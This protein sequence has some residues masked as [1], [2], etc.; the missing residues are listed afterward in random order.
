MH[1]LAARQCEDISPAAADNLYEL[2]TLWETLVTLQDTRDSS[3]PGGH[4]YSA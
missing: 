4:G 1:A 3:A 2:S